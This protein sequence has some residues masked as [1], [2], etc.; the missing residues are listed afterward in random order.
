MPARAVPLR[1]LSI[2]SRNI[3]ALEPTAALTA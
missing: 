1:V 2:S 3:I